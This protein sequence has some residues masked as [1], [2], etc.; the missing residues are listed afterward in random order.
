MADL[1]LRFCGFSIVEG[2]SDRRAENRG[3]G[4]ITRGPGTEAGKGRK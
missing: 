3:K 4:V 2:Q 1:G